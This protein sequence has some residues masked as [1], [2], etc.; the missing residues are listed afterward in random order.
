MRLGISLL[1]GVAVLAVASRPI[2]ADDKDSVKKTV[3][4]SGVDNPSGLA[5]QPKTGD[6]FV[7]AHSG[8]H[9]YQPKSGKLSDEVVGF[10]TDNYGKGPIYK[11]GPL[12]VL[13]LGDDLVVGDGGQVDGKEVVW[14]FK[15]GSKPLS[16][17]LKTG[18]NAYVLGP[19]GPD[20]VL[21]PKGEGNFYALAA[22]DK[23]LF[24]TS[25]GDDTKGW[26]LKADVK[27]G[28]ASDLKPSIATKVATGTDA[29]VGI[30]FSPG[31]KELVVGQMGEINVPADSLYTTYDP[32]TGKLLKSLKTGLNDIAGVAYSPKTGKLYVVDFSWIDT[33]K[34]G[35]FRLDIDGDNVK[36]EKLLKLDKPTSLAFDADGNLYVTEFGTAPEGSTTPAGSIS[37]I[38]AGL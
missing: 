7:A 34:G 24:V 19:I 17:P 1:V 8:I 6:I 18:D 35:L 33:S 9:R 22:N 37:K 25:N 10:S 29:P 30:T 11:I 36:T 26:V 14:V 3:V 27:D 12:G 31:K 32:A 13:F 23:A 5:V 20:P 4:A 16:A 21:T 2:S 15:V 38:P 28:R